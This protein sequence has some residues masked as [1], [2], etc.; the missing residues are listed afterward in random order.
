MRRFSPR[1]V[2]LGL[3]LLMMAALTFTTL[4][5][6]DRNNAPV[7]SQIRSLFAQERVEYFTLKGNTLTLTLR[8]QGE[9]GGSSLTYQVANPYIFYSD[10]RE[11]VDEQLASGVLKGYD[12]PPGVESA[13][14]FGMIPY[15]VA[16]AV[17]MLF[18]F[19]MFRQRGASGGGGGAP[20]A[21]KGRKEERKRTA[22]NCKT[23]FSVGGR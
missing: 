6:L 2:I 13:W 20:G 14:W 19:L 21:S 7:Y 3:L 1:D 8:G 16:V 11:L 18:W 12:Y 4:Q 10:M 15:L 23:K 17:L 22:Q 5:E 9:E